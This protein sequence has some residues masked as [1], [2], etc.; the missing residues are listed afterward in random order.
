M[1]LIYL[2]ILFSSFICSQT[3]SISLYGLGERI[4]TY[5]TNA[6]SLGSSRM[7]SSNTNNF[8]L[9]S[10]SSY[11]NNSQANLSMSVAFNR[12]DAL[13]A[14]GLKNKLESSNFNHFSF[15]FPITTK[16]YFLLSINPVF[17]S[18]LNFKEKQFNYLGA[19]NSFVDTNGDGLYDPIKYRKSFDVSGGISEIS[20]SISSSINEDI[21]LGFKIG[22]LFGTRTIQ[23]TLSFYK[24]EYD[25]SG[26]EFD[27]LQ[28]ISYE[29]RKSKF[30]YSSMS[31]LLE[32]RYSVLENSDLAFYYGK[33]SRL[34]IKENYD[35]YEQIESSAGG[36][37]DY[38]IGFKTKIYDNFG[39]ILEFQNFDSFK[40][41]NATSNFIRPSLDM[42]STNFGLFFIY[43]NISNS[44]INCL[45]FNLG[46]YDKIFKQQNNFNNIPNLTD[47]GITFGFGVEYLNK[48]SYDISF[49]LGKRSSEFSEFNDEKYFKLTFSL[50][51]N[52]DWFVKER[53]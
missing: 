46:F 14:G 37:T 2:I 30:N 19:N 16:Q 9:S 28:L 45:K 18:F 27:D 49:V 51:S 4:H 17:R 13:S 40:L 26:N 35:N 42:Q 3:S 52:N 7:F 39:Y 24:V 47:L 12:V 44:R 33:S 48:N 22:K 34:K 43:D 38:G 32:M 10:P 5:D 21:S 20:S 15:G 8:I 29:P 36:Y 31:Y 11:Y 23:D 25:L 6:L 1:S 41:Y 53:N 50:I